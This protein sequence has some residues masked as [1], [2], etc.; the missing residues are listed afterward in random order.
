MSRI[1]ISIPLKWEQYLEQLANDHQVA[2]NQVIAEL[3]K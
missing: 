1:A 3:F 2:L